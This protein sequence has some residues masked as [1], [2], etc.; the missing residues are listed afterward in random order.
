MGFAIYVFL[1]PLALLWN[2]SFWILDKIGK[3]KRPVAPEPTPAVYGH[4]V[5]GSKSQPHSTGSWRGGAFS[6]SAT[7]RPAILV[8]ALI[9]AALFTSKL[10]QTTIR[11]AV[12]E[13]DRSSRM[14]RIAWSPFDFVMRAVKQLASGKVK[15]QDLL[16]WIRVQRWFLRV[17]RR[18]SLIFQG[19]AAERRV[20]VFVL[21]AYSGNLLA[22]AALVIAFWAFC[23]KF[24]ALPAQVTVTDALLASA[25]RVV[26]GIPAPDGLIVSRSIQI[27]ASLSA[28]LIF[29][30]YVGPVASMFPVLLD[31]YALAVKELREQMRQGRGNIYRL[32]DALTGFHERVIVGGK[33]SEPPAL[34][35]APET[36]LSHQPSSGTDEI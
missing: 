28:W 34:P 20:A 9:T 3:L 24:A 26:P 14:F 1:S 22:L 13:I 5:G 19:N 7:Q 11:I 33:A 8:A 32:M 36:D 29:F 23:V 12:A 21:L 4:S 16:R 2:F 15:D 17:L 10:Y 6:S 18:L 27:G 31:R 25:S 30:L 35:S